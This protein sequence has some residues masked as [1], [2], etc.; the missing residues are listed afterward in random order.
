MRKSGDWEEGVTPRIVVAKIGEEEGN[1]R[2]SRVERL[3]V[4]PR[5]KMVGS[6]G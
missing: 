2:E 3:G 5:R 4:G 1:D 6:M